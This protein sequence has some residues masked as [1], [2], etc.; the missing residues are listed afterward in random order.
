MSISSY[1]CSLRSQKRWS[2]WP[3]SQVCDSAWRL[4]AE[5][6]IWEITKIHC[7]MFL[8]YFEIPVSRE[9]WEGTCDIM[10]DDI[11]RDLTGAQDA[12]VLDIVDRWV[13]N[14]VLVCQKTSLCK[15]A[16]H[17]QSIWKAWLA[18][19]AK[20]ERRVM[21]YSWTRLACHA[22]SCYLR[23]LSSARCSS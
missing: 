11:F 15:E 13:Q 7:G 4:S 6:G 10:A 20:R 9:S 16:G 18:A 22:R 1:A 19:T 17:L 8:V 23:N 12:A 5:S 14:G 21:P 3:R 2:R